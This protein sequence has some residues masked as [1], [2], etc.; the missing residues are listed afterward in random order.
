MESTEAHTF[1][2]TTPIPE[3]SST[4]FSLP[5]IFEREGTTESPEPSREFSQVTHALPTNF[6]TVDNDPETT[7]PRVTPSS[8]A[9]V[10]LNF[11]TPD[12]KDDTN[13]ITTSQG[14]EITSP[15]SGVSSESPAS[16][17]VETS[18]TPIGQPR[19]VTSSTDSTV[20]GTSSVSTLETSALRV[21]TSPK[22]TVPSETGTT[23]T[24]SKAITVRT[25]E[26]TRLSMEVS[27]PEPTG[28]STASTETASESTGPT[29]K[30][31]LPSTL[32]SQQSTTKSDET[33]S[34]ESHSEPTTPSTKS[35]S[36][37]GSSKTSGSGLTNR[38]S[39]TT[40]PTTNIPG[41]IP[42]GRKIP[43]DGPSVTAE[44]D[45]IGQST[46][47]TTSPG[48]KEMST[49]QNVPVT[50]VTTDDS[51]MST[52]STTHIPGRIPSGRKI[53]SD[54][55]SVTAEIDVAG[56]STSQTISPESKE[57]STQQTAPDRSLTTEG[58]ESLPTTRESPEISTGFTP[59]LKSS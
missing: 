23:A 39:M 55:P 27:S 41:R 6:V 25:Q 58:P 20:K 43:S 59:G 17:N 53:P 2:S 12:D 15:P 37:D 45:V 7:T 16:Q 21:R 22:Q 13:V 9:A 57:M 4:T 32:P 11:F 36:P 29:T 52:A 40:A 3:E 31:A 47:Q 14:I 10:I 54:G 56:Q 44:T 46:S 1:T 26:S 18:T 35:S 48:S 28:F 34:R 5:K 51:S 50:S 30:E 8:T 33:T 38:S 24:F 42:S 19:R 49:Q